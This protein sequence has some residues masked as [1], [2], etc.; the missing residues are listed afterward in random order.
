[1][2]PSTLRPLV[3]PMRNP[4]SPKRIKVAVRLLQ[5]SKEH[6]NAYDLVPDN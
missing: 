6:T 2:L 5:A 4:T 1:M 3:G